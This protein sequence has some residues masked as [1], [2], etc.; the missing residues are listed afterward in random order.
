MVFF[1]KFFCQFLGQIRLNYRALKYQP[2]RNEQ[3]YNRTQNW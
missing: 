3:D 2:G 1:G